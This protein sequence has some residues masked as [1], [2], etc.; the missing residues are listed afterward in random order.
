MDVNGNKPEFRGYVFTEVEGS[1]K[2]DPND[3]HFE[4]LLDIHVG[5]PV[6]DNLKISWDMEHAKES[7]VGNVITDDNDESELIV[8]KHQASGLIAN[9][10]LCKESKCNDC[11][12]HHSYNDCYGEHHVYCPSNSLHEYFYALAYSY[13]KAFNVPSQWTNYENENK[14]VFRFDTTTLVI[15]YIYY[16]D[17]YECQ[18]YECLDIGL[19]HNEVQRMVD[20]ER[21]ARGYTDWK[22]DDEWD[23]ERWLSGK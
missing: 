23:N 3:L 21:I 10:R 22:L 9:C 5:K 13:E 6:P 17:S 19:Y 14:V 4:E 15:R 2:R 12:N 11:S 8:E 1:K 7:I 20:Q 16:P 18:G